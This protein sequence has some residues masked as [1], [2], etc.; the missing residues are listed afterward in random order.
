MDGKRSWNRLLAARRASPTTPTSSPPSCAATAPAGCTT[1]RC[2]TSPT[3]RVFGLRARTRR[4]TW[5]CSR[6]A[7]PPS[8]VQTRGDRAARRASPGT[9]TAGSSGSTRP[10][11]ARHFD[12]V[13]VHPYTGAVDPTL[14]WN[15]AGT[16]RKA[17]D[18]FCGIEEVHASMV[19]AG[20]GGQAHLGDG[21]RLVDAHG[22]TMACHEAV[23]ADYLSKGFERLE[24]LPVGPV[25]ALVLVPQRLRPSPTTRRLGGQHG[26]RAGR[27][28]RPSPRCRRCATTRLRR[29]PRRRPN[30]PPPRSRRRRRPR[31]RRPRRRRSPSPPRSR[32]RRSTARSRTAPR[33]ATIAASRV[34]SSCSTARSWQPTARRRTREAGRYRGVSRRGPTSPVFEPSTRPARRVRRRWPSGASAGAASRAW[35]RVRR[36]R[37]SRHA[38]AGSCAGGA[39]S[40]PRGPRREARGLRTSPGLAHGARQADRAPALRRTIPLA[41]ARRR[42]PRRQLQ[43]RR[44][45]LRDPSCETVREGLSRP[46]LLTRASTAPSRPSPPWR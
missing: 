13:A 43:G 32:A 24:S 20:D 37:R 23:Q 14:C 15:Q 3:T 29:V 1:S 36:P 16:T 8:D 17:K 9:T 11:P 7:R 31:S 6:Q 28:S 35:R 4:S 33:S 39:G 30:R 22:P 40:R 21:V 46:S 26:S 19:A 25:P 12:A 2:G 44:P 42:R 41:P 5:S 10:G 38:A 34:S 45:L 27:A 18:A